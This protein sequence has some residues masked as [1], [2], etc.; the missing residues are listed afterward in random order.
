MT[1]PRGRAATDEL[2]FTYLYILM[3]KHK[4]ESQWKNK[5]NSH[6]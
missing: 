3:L 4:D 5:K 6:I 1:G 2:F